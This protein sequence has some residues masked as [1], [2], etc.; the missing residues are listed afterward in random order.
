MARRA[1]LN[2]F[3]RVANQSCQLHSI[4]FHP[5]IFT[6]YVTLQPQIQDF[7]WLGTA[8]SLRNRECVGYGKSTVDQ[9]LRSSAAVTQLEAVI[10]AQTR[11]PAELGGRTFYP[12]P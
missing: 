8:R 7:D 5:D 6:V 3:L 12:T 1:F 11:L 9:A 10:E 4:A 2:P